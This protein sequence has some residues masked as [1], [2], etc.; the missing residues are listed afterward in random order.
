M[1][2]QPVSLLRPNCVESHR[3]EGSRYRIRAGVGEEIRGEGEREGGEGGRNVELCGWAGRGG[4]QTV[5]L[6]Q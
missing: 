6:G 3:L 5:S 2:T 4:G 1:V